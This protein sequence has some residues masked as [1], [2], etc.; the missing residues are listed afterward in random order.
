[1]SNT[2]KSNHP[3]T[4]LSAWQV[5]TLLVSTSYGIGFLFGSG[6]VAL[7]WGMAGSIYAVITA[8]GIAVL[9]F[10]APKVWRNGMQIWQMLGAAYGAKVSRLVALLSVVW[11]SGVLAAQIHGGVA[12]MQLMGASRMPAY[13][14]M[15]IL[16]FAASRMK[17]EMA[18]K[19]FAVCLMAS[20]LALIH[21]LFS[22]DGLPVLRSAVPSFANDLQL[23]PT[24]RLWAIAL[25]VAPLV[26]TGADYQQFVIAAR[27]PR[28]AVLGCLM[29]AGF[30]FLFGFVPAAIV[31][32]YENVSAAAHP[33]YGNQII[34]FIMSELFQRL[35]SGYGWAMLI[36]LLTAALGS[37]AAIVRAMSAATLSAVDYKHQSDG[38]NLVMILLG[39]LI[40]SRG[41]AIIDTMVALNM[42]YLGAIGVVLVALLVRWKVSAQSAWLAMLAGFIASL[43]GY[44]YGWAGLTTLD[45]D[46]FSLVAGLL[47]SLLVFG[48]CAVTTRTTKVDLVSPVRVK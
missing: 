48:L 36:G 35:A 40:A 31:L 11:M 2:L 3:S 46:L 25:A 19:V 21:A 26:V 5:A 47:A 22:I 42:V 27:T 32:A 18:A 45:T 15:L 43:L 12:V 14:L 44:V 41:Q 6:E 8:L 9:A 4:N 17:L 29:A 33:A 20:S 24:D 30:L 10:V 28:A 16:I 23:I 7:R 34:P 13:A 39:G 1:M 38:T 37:A